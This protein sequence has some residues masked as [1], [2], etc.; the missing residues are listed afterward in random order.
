[1]AGVENITKEIL[2]DAEESSAGIIKEAEDK[3]KTLIDEAKS[4]IKEV[5][6]KAQQS[7]AAEKKK[8]IDRA[9]SEAETNEKR[10]VLEARNEIIDDIIDKAYEKLTHES[11][12]EYFSMIYSLLE[13]NVHAESGE[14]QISSAD[15]KR[16]PSDFET[17]ISEIAG[18]KNGKLTLSSEDADIDY[19]FIL[20]Y[21]GID[22]NC[23]L[24]ALFS[25]KRTE[26]SDL[27]YKKL[28]P[29]ES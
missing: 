27:V 21:G 15:R 7:T 11:D 5:S 2:R 20:S 28:W 6:E 17:K 26:F 25:D 16:L 4:E 1:M 23:S 24:K 9:K 14:M 3:K 12:S 13:K 8:F 18:K 19:G 22:E 29:K 10:A